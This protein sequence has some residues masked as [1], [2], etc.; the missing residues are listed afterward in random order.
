MSNAEPQGLSALEI[1]LQRESVLPDHE[2]RR[3]TISG[4][5]ISP[6][7]FAPPTSSTPE[8]SEK[9]SKKKK[10]PL[11]ETKNLHKSYRKG[12]LTIPV[13]RGV[14]F[15]AEEGKITTIIGQ[16]GSGKS[17]L[18]HL[19]G[20]LDSPDSG[21]INFANTRIDKLSIRQR[22]AL[23]SRAFGMIFQFYHLLPELT[24]LENVLTP[25]M[26]SHG[27][28]SYWAARKKF[29]K[30]A[31]ELLE[32]VGLGHRITHKPRELS[33]G[34]MQRTAI[35]RALIAQ[36]RI[37]LADEPTGNLDE[38]TGGEI[39]EILKRLNREQNLTIVM[40]THDNAIAAQGH[41][42]IRLTGG[43]VE[44]T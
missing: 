11:L 19:M 40:V 20:T 6:A 43:R 32:M 22:D 13:L 34:E 33:G 27:M 42:V 18:L 7:K 23:R 26:I 21:E 25:I 37:L 30:R 9:P 41:E 2:V 36:P 3:Q 8:A 1:R 38:Q 31:E 4:P 16:S 35:A 28:W 44:K 15:A 14:D 24:T 17:T 5:H 29:R 10:K 12:R 39:M